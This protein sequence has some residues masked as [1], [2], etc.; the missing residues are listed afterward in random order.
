[1]ARLRYPP[2]YPDQEA[3][4]VLGSDTTL[5]RWPN[6]TAETV[7]GWAYGAIPQWIAAGLVDLRQLDPTLRFD[8]RY[9]TAHN[10]L[11]EMI[12]PE[13]VPLLRR[14]AAKALVAANQ[15]LHKWGLGLQVWDAYRPLAVQRLMWAKV[16]DRHY[17]ADPARGGSAHNRGIAVDVTLV[18]VDGAPLAMPTDFDDFTAAAAHTT[19]TGL[20]KEQRFNRA[21]LRLAM[22]LHGFRPLRSEWWHYTYPLDHAE[23]LDVPLE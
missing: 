15:F 16:P 17:V 7:D 8:L 11:G 10:F 21:I 18:T 14:K 12:Y 2:S 3:L 9:A 6:K 19:R 20:T 1:V 4:P 23:A 5:Y 13:A 22:K